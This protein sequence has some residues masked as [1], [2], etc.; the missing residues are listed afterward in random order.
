MMGTGRAWAMMAIREVVRAY[1]F[2]F[3]TLVAIFA[4]IAGFSWLAH[5]DVIAMWLAR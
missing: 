2:R 3:V 5:H 1:A 4:L